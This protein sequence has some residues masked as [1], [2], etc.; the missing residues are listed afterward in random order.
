MKE[1][2]KKR[3]LTVIHLNCCELN[4][5]GYIRHS[6]RSNNTDGILSAEVIHVLKVK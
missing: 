1:K 4:N 3:D 5:K 2:S 6:E